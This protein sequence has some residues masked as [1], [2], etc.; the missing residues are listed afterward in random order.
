MSNIY[1]IFSMFKQKRL[2]GIRDKIYPYFRAQ[3]NNIGRIDI[4]I[5]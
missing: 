5:R 1:S 2:I 3:G 4:R